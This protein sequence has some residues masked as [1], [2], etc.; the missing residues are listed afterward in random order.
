MN[1]PTTASRIVLGAIVGWITAPGY[2]EFAEYLDLSSGWAH[3]RMIITVCAGMV[4]L[5][6]R[7]YVLIAKR[8]SN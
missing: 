2:L 7:L 3:P 8:L 1:K 4:I 5:I 6:D